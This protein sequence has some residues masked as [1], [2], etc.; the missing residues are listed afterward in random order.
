MVFEFDSDGFLTNRS[1]EL[2]AGVYASHTDL[3]EGARQIN[4]ECHELLFSAD[5]RNRDVQAI[6]TAMLLMRALEHYQATIILLG[7]GLIAAARVTLRAQVETIFR[8]RAIATNHDALKVFITEDR[9]H[10]KRLINTAR[11]NAH[12]NL[13]ETRRAI[14]DDLVK[15]L[16]QQIKSAGAK[17]LSTEDWSKLADMHDWYTTNYR[18]LSKAAHTQIRDLE[19]YLI[20]GASGDIQELDYAPSMDEIPL[21]ILTAAYLLLIAASAFDKTFELGFGPK[22][23]ELFKFVDSGFRALE[24]RRTGGGKAGRSGARAGAGQVAGK[25]RY[26][27]T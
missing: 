12:P 18:L 6:I 27:V 22:G 19:A 10:R 17:A 16:E 24:G 11:N 20:Q 8:I 23:D 26:A 14:T 7:R 21:L 3:F 4:H 9:V 13:E 5:I 1:N 15:E 2:E 25:R